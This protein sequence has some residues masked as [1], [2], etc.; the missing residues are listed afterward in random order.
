MPNWSD[1]EGG[2]DCP[3][4][5][6]AGLGRHREGEAG[7]ISGP[8]LV[9]SE[10]DLKRKQKRV[11][12]I[13][14]DLRRDLASVRNERIVLLNNILGGVLKDL[15]AIFATPTARARVDAKKDAKPKTEIRGVVPKG[16]KGFYSNVE[17]LI[18]RSSI[19]QAAAAEEGFDLSS[20]PDDVIRRT[21]E[22]ADE[23]E[24]RDR[25]MI[26]CP[27]CKR[28]PFT[29]LHLVPGEELARCADCL[30]EIVTGTKTEE[31]PMKNPCEDIPLGDHVDH[32]S[33]AARDFDHR[34]V[35]AGGGDEDED[36]EV[37]VSRSQLE[38]LVQKANELG[39]TVQDCIHQAF[40]LGMKHAGPGTP[41]ITFNTVEERAAAAKI[42]FEV[43]HH[44]EH[45]AGKTKHTCPEDVAVHADCAGCLMDFTVVNNKTGRTWTD[46][47]I[48]D[49]VVPPDE[50]K[51]T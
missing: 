32:A 41:A 5:H 17:E 2:C 47:P 48:S 39:K 33:R 43:K 49:V 28:R 36:E 40:E 21:L 42:I 1:G 4:G 51:K 14:H 13:L 19:G 11:L 18:V 37:V 9:K 30:F 29:V 25:A 10:A 46:D 22:R 34:A 35:G 38:M 3:S 6:A 31:T 8:E 26:T 16:K 15:E 27:R 23:L 12:H 50:E 20:V 24:R 44:G 45:F 7:C